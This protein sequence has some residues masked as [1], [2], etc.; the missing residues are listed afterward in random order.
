MDGNYIKIPT[1][2]STGKRTMTVISDIPGFPKE[3]VKSKGI[4]GMRY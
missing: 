4:N 2:T 1:I 3:Q